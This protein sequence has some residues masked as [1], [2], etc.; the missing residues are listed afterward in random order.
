M[1]HNPNRIHTAQ[2]PIVTLP[3]VRDARPDQLGA[4]T[5]RSAAERLRFGN[6]IGA[7]AP[8]ARPSLLDHDGQGGDHLAAASADTATV[9]GSRTTT[10]GVRRFAPDTLKTTKTRSHRNAVSIAEA[11][12]TDSPGFPSA[13]G[14][15]VM[16]MTVRGILGRNNSSR[17]EARKQALVDRHGWP[18]LRCIAIHPEGIRIVDLIFSVPF[19]S[20]HPSGKMAS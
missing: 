12:H 11:D 18:H 7:A 3:A 10:M 15:A 2:G 6:S 9:V 17:R 20:R 8:I 4:V 19:Q 16:P 13:H 5:G 1:W 14:C